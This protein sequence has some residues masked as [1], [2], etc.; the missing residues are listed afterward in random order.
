VK[1][2]P[3][4]H[5]LIVQLGAVFTLARFSEAFSHLRAQSLGLAVGYIPAVMIAMNV[6]Y[7]GVAYPPVWPPIASAIARCSRSASPCS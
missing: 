6:V 7:A 5:W 1:Q 3:R 4:R 2:L